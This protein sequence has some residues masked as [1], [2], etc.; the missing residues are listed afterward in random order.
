[1]GNINFIEKQI[2]LSVEQLR[3]PKEIRNQLDIGF[4]FSNNVLEIFEIRPK[5]DDESKNIHTPVAKCKYIKTQECWKIYWM[6]ANGK[7]EA[8]PPNPETKTILGFF[9][10]LKEDKN[11]CFWG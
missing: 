5:W 11:S 8:Y 4:I 10:I 3:P 6:R 9:E 2:E 7:W 1:M